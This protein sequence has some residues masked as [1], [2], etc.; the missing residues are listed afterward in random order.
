MAYNNIVALLD[1]TINH[2]ILLSKFE[3]YGFGKKAVALLRNYLNTEMS[4]NQTG[5]TCGIPQGTILGPLRFIIYI[6]DLPNC[7]EHAAPRMFAD[8][9]SLTAVG[10]TLNKAEEIA[11]KDL[12]NVKAWLSSNKLS[13]DIAKTE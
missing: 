12:N 10:K 13:L 2:E 1:L 6:N 11:N 7:L 4:T 3:R 8:D 9:T 5:I